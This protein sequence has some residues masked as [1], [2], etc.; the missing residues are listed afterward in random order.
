LRR[1]YENNIVGV[2][3]FGGI[4]FIVLALGVVVSIIFIAIFSVVMFLKR[5]REARELEQERREW[6]EI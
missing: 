5:K 6:E 4:S 3:M 2:V 1:V